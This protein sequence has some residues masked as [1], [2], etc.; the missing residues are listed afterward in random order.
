MEYALSVN[1][2]WKH[3]SVYVDWTEIAILKFLYH[4]WNTIKQINNIECIESVSISRRND[5]EIM[6]HNWISGLHIQKYIGGQKSENNWQKIMSKVI[7][8]ITNHL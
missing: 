1:F 8:L 2:P 3:F 4:L 5:S 6:F 7:L